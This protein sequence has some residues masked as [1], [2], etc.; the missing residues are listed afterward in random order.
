MLRKEVLRKETLRRHKNNKERE[1]LEKPS[2]KEI[3]ERAAEI[4]ATWDRDTEL[5]RR[6]AK[7]CPAI[8]IWT[9]LFNSID[10][11]KLTD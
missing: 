5:R 4:R 11:G 10:N 1:N 2:A 7:P 9:Q 3:K 8:I 6:V